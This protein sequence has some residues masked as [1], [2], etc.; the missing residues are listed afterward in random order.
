MVRFN[1]VSLPR[2]TYTRASHLQL[3]AMHRSSLAGKSIFALTKAL[4]SNEHLRDVIT[5]TIFGELRRRIE[6]DVD[7]LLEQDKLSAEDRER[8]TYVS[9]QTVDA[10]DRDYVQR[11]TA[12]DDQPDGGNTELELTGAA[13]V[14][15]VCQVF[16][17]AKRFPSLPPS[18]CFASVQQNRPT[19]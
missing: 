2:D 8:V 5:A 17:L 14:S 10:A 9:Q 3:E 11:D 13:P 18:L 4:R 15:R 12:A 19:T 1:R 16:G 7:R 6:N